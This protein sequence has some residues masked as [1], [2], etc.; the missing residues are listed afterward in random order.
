MAYGYFKDLKRRTAADKVLS[1]KALI[2][3]ENLKYEQYQR[4][5][6]LVIYKFLIKKLLVEQ[7]KMKMSNKVLSKELHKYY[8]AWEKKVHSSFIDN[9]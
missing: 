2:I 1:D 7:L 3:H 9:I 8:R 4:R 6:P 5:L